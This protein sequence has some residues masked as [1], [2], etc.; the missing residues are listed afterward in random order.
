MVY[1]CL[2]DLYAEPGDQILAPNFIQG[3][4]LVAL[5]VCE[6]QPTQPKESSSVECISIR[7]YRDGKH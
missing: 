5:C 3:C 2:G 7:Y 6:S 1:G 4:A